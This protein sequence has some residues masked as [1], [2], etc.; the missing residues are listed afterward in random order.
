MPLD[1]FG[2]EVKESFCQPIG[3]HFSIKELQ[4]GFKNG[5]FLQMIWSLKLKQSENGN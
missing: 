3:I 5:K 1:E 2:G 4:T